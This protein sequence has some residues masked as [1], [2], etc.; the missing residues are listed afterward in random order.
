M[1]ISAQ[2]TNRRAIGCWLEQPCRNVTRS[3]RS[4]ERVQCNA[5]GQVL[6]KLK[7]PW[8]DGTTQLVISPLEFIQ[9]L[10]YCG[11]LDCTRVRRY[12][13]LDR[14]LLGGESRSV[15]YRCGSTAGSLADQTASRRTCRPCPLAILPTVANKDCRSVPV[16]RDRPLG[17][18]TSAMTVAQPQSSIFKR[19]RVRTHSRMPAL[20]STSFKDRPAPHVK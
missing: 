9:R 3:A 8:R 6:P 11:A 5:A 18:R 15:K 17:A 14:Q 10:L 12:H 4:D 16:L 20:S 1:A 13:A 19:C 7:T 2:S